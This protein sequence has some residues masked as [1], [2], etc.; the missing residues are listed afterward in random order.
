MVSPFRNLTNISDVMNM[1]YERFC[2]DGDAIRSYFDYK[3]SL[4][5]RWRLQKKRWKI[6][7]TGLCVRRTSG[8]SFLPSLFKV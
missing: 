2:L 5:D 3:K 4:F 7:H 6:L 1:A 8:S